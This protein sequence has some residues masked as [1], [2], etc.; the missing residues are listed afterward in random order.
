MSKFKPVKYEAD[1]CRLEV[2]G[3]LLE[4]DSPQEA[5]RQ[6]RQGETVF[7]AAWRGSFYGV[8]RDEKNVMISP[9]GIVAVLGIEYSCTVAPCV[10]LFGVKSL[11]CCFSP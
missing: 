6:Y 3:V 2:Y 1:G 7:W 4:A 8:L 10:V 5:I 11:G 9:F